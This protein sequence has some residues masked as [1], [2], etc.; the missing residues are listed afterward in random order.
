MYLVLVYLVET[1]LSLSTF[2]HN[3]EYKMKRSLLEL[4]LPNYQLEGAMSRIRLA[5]CQRFP[6]RRSVVRCFPIASIARDEAI[7]LHFRCQKTEQA[8][9]FI[10]KALLNIAASAK[11]DV[12]RIFTI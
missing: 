12:H 6:I 1:Q 10:R 8:F 11:L 9:S 2:T 3:F 7:L 5:I 4:K